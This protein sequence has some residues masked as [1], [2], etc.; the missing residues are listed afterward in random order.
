M[1]SSMCDDDEEDDDGDDDNDSDYDDDDDDGADDDDGDESSP[2][3]LQWLDVVVLLPRG[4]CTTIQ[5]L[6]VK[7][8]TLFALFFK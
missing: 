2:Q 3:G 1:M 6:Q 5:E 4:R 7:L 8:I